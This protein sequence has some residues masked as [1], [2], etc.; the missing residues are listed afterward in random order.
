[1]A[2]PAALGLLLTLAAAP[3]LLLTLP[4]AP[5]LQQAKQQLVPRQGRA[6]QE[7][8]REAGVQRW[9]RSGSRLRCRGCG[10]AQHRR[11]VCRQ[12]LLCSARTVRRQWCPGSSA[13]CPE[14]LPAELG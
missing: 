14:R 10:T 8:G 9:L 7:M 3:G 4:A 13:G 1:M 12:A 2:L 11:Q 6:R 5:G